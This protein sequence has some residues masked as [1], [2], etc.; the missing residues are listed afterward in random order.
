MASHPRFTNWYSLVKEP[1]D[2]TGTTVIT[3]L[4]SDATYMIHKGWGDTQNISGYINFKNGETSIT[5]EFTLALNEG[6]EAPDVTFF[7]L[8]TSEPVKLSDLKGQVV[9]LDFWAS[10]CGP[11][12]E[13]MGKNQSIMKKRAGDWMGKATI[14]AASVDADQQAALRHVNRKGWTAMRHVWCGDKDK[15]KNA[16]QIFGVKGIPAAFLINKKGVIVW[17]GH[18]ANFKLEEEIERLLAE[19]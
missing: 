5:Q 13:P 15:E 2:E 18:P 10:W 12:Q 6:D 7:D 8:E 19:P 3:G 17:A 14:L 1:V 11:C 9:L 16:S 4:S